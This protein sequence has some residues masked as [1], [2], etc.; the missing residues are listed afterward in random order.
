MPLNY[1]DCIVECTEYIQSVE[2]DENID[3]KDVIDGIRQRMSIMISKVLT[4]NHYT[5][6]TFIGWDIKTIT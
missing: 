4:N 5:S 2:H 1:F 6:G 3:K